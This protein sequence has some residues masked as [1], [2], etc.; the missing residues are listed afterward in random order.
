MSTH[1]LCKDCWIAHDVTTLLAR[2][3]RCEAN[4]RIHRLDPL[5]SKAPSRGLGDAGP[6]VC[7]LHPTEPLDVFCGTCRGGVPPRTRITE[8]GVLAILGDTESGKTSL[9]W[10]LSERLRQPNGA[11]MMIRTAL[12]DSDAQMLRSVREIFDSGRLSATPATDAD[13]RNYAWEVANAAGET[14]VLAFHDAAGEVWHDLP[15]LSRTSYDAFYRYLDLV[16]SIVFAIDGVR[17]A[18]ALDT[19]SRGGLPS[20]QLRSAQINE[21]A[22]VDAISRR[23]NAR[24][25]RVPA[26]VV[27]TKADMLWNRDDCTAFQPASEATAEAIDGAARD[28]LLRAGR[29]QLVQSLVDTFDPVRFF[30]VSA[31]GRTP[32][33]PL[34]LEELSPV[35][36]EEPFVALLG[37]VGLRV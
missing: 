20:P 33:L 11:G 37:T 12:G 19:M 7:R 36:V 32:R 13:V 5:S 27:I 22:I 17:V 6:L 35:R 2:C 18:E 10:V 21:L 31:F 3:K 28:V 26:A 8:G 25:Q 23:M 14:T 29:Q 4:T 1:L 24:S 16:G 15:N 30:A 9:L 34:R